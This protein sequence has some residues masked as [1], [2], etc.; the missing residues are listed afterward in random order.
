MS[1][2]QPH[3]QYLLIA[4]A[5]KEIADAGLSENALRNLGVLE[6]ISKLAPLEAVID[7]N[8]NSTNSG[9]I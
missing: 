2:Q 8:A 1:R 4:N 3:K 5:L 6:L 9:A 7:G